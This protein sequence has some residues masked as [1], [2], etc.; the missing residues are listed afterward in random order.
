MGPMARP[1]LAAVAQAESADVQVI[2]LLA[3]LS[4]SFDCASSADMQLVLARGV[5][6]ARIIFANPY[7][8]KSDLEYA[9]EHGILKTTFDNTD[10]LVKIEKV[11][12][13]AELFLRIL[14]GDNG[15]KINLNEKFGATPK[16]AERL[17]C[18][19]KE[20]ALDI[21]CVSFRIGSGAT[22]TDSF[23]AQSTTPGHCSITAD[24]EHRTT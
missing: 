19:V 20:L 22:N 16:S 18:L 24:L 8:S 2:R 23:E 14:T 7:K 1:I 15:A 13:H 4:S 3:S 21:V 9:R 5:E 10:E 6:L 17:L 11:H 12:P